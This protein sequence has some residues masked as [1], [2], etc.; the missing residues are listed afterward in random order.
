M[1]HLAGLLAVRRED[2]VDDGADDVLDAG[3][4]VIEGYEPE[5]SLEACT[6]NGGGPSGSAPRD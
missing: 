2:L 3:K 6:P 4:E 1:V 5:L